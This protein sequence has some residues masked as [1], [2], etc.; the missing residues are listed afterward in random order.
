VSGRRAV[1]IDSARAI[2][3]SS[4]R[5]AEEDPMALADWLRVFRTVHD[6]A[7]AGGLAPKDLEDYRAGCDELA[8]ALMAAQR[9]PLR[10]GE[11]PRHQLRVARALQV[12]LETPLSR[13]RAMTVD[14]SVAGFSVLAAKAPPAGEEQTATVR[15]P[16]GEPVVATVVPAELKQ[17]P[18]TVRVSF[19]FKKLADA[20]RQRLELLVID[21]AL[22]QL[23][24]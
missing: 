20:E 19:T 17:Q 23:A 1:A 13:V 16:G 12:D 21:T 9:L 5:G 24:G 3:V 7:K 4:P 15:V 14:V 8:R 10:P 18:G 11:P 22:S 6:K 2:V